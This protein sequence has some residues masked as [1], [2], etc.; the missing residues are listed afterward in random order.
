MPI[1]SSITLRYTNS[2]RM[3]VQC[4]DFGR[5]GQ[6]TDDSTMRCM[7]FACWIT[8]AANTHFMTRCPARY[9]AIV[10]LL[11]RVPDFFFLFFESHEISVEK[12]SR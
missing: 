9:K 1:H 11:F 12:L 6:A 4:G 10:Q 3:T 7:H 2:S 8:K 5:A